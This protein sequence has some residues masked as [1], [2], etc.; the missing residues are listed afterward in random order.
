MN[1]ALKNDE[2][3]ALFVRLDSFLERCHDIL[4]L[5]RIRIETILT[6]IL[7]TVLTTILT[8]RFMCADEH[9]V[10]VLEARGTSGTLA[11]PL[12][13]CCSLRA[14]AA[15]CSLLPNGASNFSVQLTL[16][17]LTHNNLLS[18]HRRS[19]LAGRRARS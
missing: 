15:R 11:A 17:P 5:V 9:G 10:A 18:P 14:M 16:L 8:T 7:T 12:L 3:A 2:F 1:F 13:C 4:E 19:R 6:T